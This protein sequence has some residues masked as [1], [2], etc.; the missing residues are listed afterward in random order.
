M[1]GPLRGETTI[2]DPLQ[3]ATGPAQWSRPLSQMSP[4]NAP[5]G[6]EGLQRLALQANMSCSPNDFESLV[7]SSLA[8]VAFHMAFLYE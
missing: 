2:L 5:A 7:L 1:E 4:F 6:P 3:A 8:V